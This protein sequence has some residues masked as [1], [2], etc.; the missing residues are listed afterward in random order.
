MSDKLG[1]SVKN[2]SLGHTM[3]TQDLSNIQFSVLL[4]LV[5]GVHR[6]EMYRLGEPINNHPYGVKHVGRE[7]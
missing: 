3:E 4:S 7:R 1:S 6:N 2:D 5:V